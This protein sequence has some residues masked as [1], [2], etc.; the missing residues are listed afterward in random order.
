MKAF[1]KLNIIKIKADKN[2]HIANALST[3]TV[4]KTTLW[5]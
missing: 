1:P 3:F 2:N 4:A 5:K